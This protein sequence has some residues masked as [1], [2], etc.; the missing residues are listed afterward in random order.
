VNPKNIL[1]TSPIKTLATGKLRNINP[2]EATAIDLTT[3]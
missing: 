1:P 2:K 3:H